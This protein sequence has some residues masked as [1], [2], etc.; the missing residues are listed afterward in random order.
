MIYLFILVFFYFS[1]GEAAVR[2][3]DGCFIFYF[4]FITVPSCLSYFWVARVKKIQEYDEAR[5]NMLKVKIL[6]AASA[7]KSKGKLYLEAILQNNVHL[8]VFIY[9]GVLY[10][11]AFKYGGMSWKYVPFYPGEEEINYVHQL[12]KKY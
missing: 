10:A 1:Y 5:F 4:I 2:S 7:E 12:S 11:A 6:D 8:T 9:E 3:M